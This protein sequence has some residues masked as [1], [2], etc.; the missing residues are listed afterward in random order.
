MDLHYSAEFVCQTQNSPR[1]RKPD[2]DWYKYACALV[3]LRRM[4]CCSLPSFRS[5]SSHR[6]LRRIGFTV[7]VLVI[8]RECGSEA[9]QARAKQ[10]CLELYFATVLYMS[11]VIVLDNIM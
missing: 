10:Q 5:R 3:F 2:G 6:P 7:E 8:L 9:F 11:V 4:F 1:H